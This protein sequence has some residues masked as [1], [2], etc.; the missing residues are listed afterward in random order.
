MWRRKFSKTVPSIKM[1]FFNLL[2]GVSQLPFRKKSRNGQSLLV[3]AQQ[4]LLGHAKLLDQ[5]K[6]YCGWLF[7]YPIIVLLKAEAVEAVYSGM[8]S[9][10]KPFFYRFGNPFFG[11]S[12]GTR[13]LP[14]LNIPGDCVGWPSDSFLFPK[15]KEFLS[16]I[17]FSTGSDVKT[18]A[19][20]WFNGQ[21]SDFYPAGLNKLVLRSDK[22]LNR[23][24]DYVEK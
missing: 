18:A 3:F 4:I 8:K 13:R 24:G 11:N 9:V 19:K 17:G 1:R 12:V 6:L 10:E 7:F 15:L 16:G 23:F 14:S 22:F 21:G 5:E 20:N 2:G